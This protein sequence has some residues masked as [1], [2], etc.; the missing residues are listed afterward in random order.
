MGV[1]NQTKSRC[2]K[3]VRYCGTVN[4]E[5]EFIAA[6]ATVNQA[7]WLRKF[8]ANLQVVQTDS[9]KVFVDNQ[10]VIAISDNSVFHRKT[11]HFNIKLYFL[12]EVQKEGEV[13]LEYC[14]TEDQLADIFTK[15]LPKGR[16]ENLRKK[17]G[18]NSY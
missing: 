8:L 6:T 16:F 7:L 9:T 11:K 3:E 13:L 15:A 1:Q 14:K 5:A 18:V 10:V 17:L 4:A 2:F 12:K